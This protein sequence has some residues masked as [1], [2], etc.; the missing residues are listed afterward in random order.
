[1]GALRKSQAP[2]ILIPFRVHFEDGTKIVVPAAHA[3]EA[4]KGAKAL[5]PDLII[6]KIKTV[7][8]R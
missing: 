4:Q 6:R 7:K 5:Y 2:V 3:D 8:E 1:M